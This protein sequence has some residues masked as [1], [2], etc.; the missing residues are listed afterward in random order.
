MDQKSNF[1]L[2]DKPNRIETH[3]PEILTEE[4]NGVTGTSGNEKHAADR[5]GHFGDSTR[6]SIDFHRRIVLHTPGAAVASA[7]LS[8]SL[9]EVENRESIWGRDSRKVITHQGLPSQEF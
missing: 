5:R 1:R 3:E 2:K 6:S 7:V 4:S 8:L 9:S